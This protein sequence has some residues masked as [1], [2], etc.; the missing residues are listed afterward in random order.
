MK[1]KYNSDENLLSE[2][3]NNRNSWVV[4]AG[5]L[6]GGPRGCSSWVLLVGAPRG[7]SSWVVLV[8]GPRGCSSP[9][10]EH[11]KILSEKQYKKFASYMLDN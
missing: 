11:Q 4:F 8:G 7:W 10:L 5:V 3:Q 1:V 2:N 6:V 9:R